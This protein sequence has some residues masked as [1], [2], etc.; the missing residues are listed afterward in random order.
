MFETSQTIVWDVHTNCFK[1]PS[2]AGHIKNIKSNRGSIHVLAKFNIRVV[3]AD[4]CLKHALCMYVDS[5][6]TWVSPT[7]HVHWTFLNHVLQ[8]LWKLS[9]FEHGHNVHDSPPTHARVIVHTRVDPDLTEDSDPNAFQKKC[10]FDK[11]LLQTHSRQNVTQSDFMAHASLVL[12]V[13]AASCFCIV[14]AIITS[15]RPCRTSTPEQKQTHIQ[16]K[17]LCFHYENVLLNK[18]GNA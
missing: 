7:L 16:W 15:T 13:G 4:L 12:F 2:C 10:F 11:I 17:C 14:A 6:G 5:L 18:D 8:V 1:P 9:Q 3:H